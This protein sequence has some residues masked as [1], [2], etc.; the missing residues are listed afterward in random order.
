MEIRDIGGIVANSV[1]AFFQNEHYAR[2]IDKLLALGVCPQ[3]VQK[4]SGAQ[5]FLDQ[6]F[7]L[8]GTL[9][10]FKRSEAQKIIQDLGG[11]TAGSVSSRTSYVLAGEAAGSKLQKA[12]ELGVKIISEQDFTELI[13]PYR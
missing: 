7:V 13:K 9:E 12:R 1:V 4:T 10:H 5:P 8:T 2:I 11:K 3:D 6:T